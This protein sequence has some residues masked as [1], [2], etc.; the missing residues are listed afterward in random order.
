MNIFNKEKSPI[1]NNWQTNRLYNQQEVQK[2]SSSNPQA[3]PGT[4][5]THP[6]VIVRTSQLQKNIEVT[7]KATDQRSPIN[8]AAIRTIVSEQHP[9]REKLREVLNRANLSIR[10]EDKEK[11]PKILADLKTAIEQ[12]RQEIKKGG[13]LRQI[14]HL[15]SKTFGF[16]ITVKAEQAYENF[17]NSLSAKDQEYTQ[18]IYF[19]KIGTNEDNGS[20]GLKL[21]SGKSRAMYHE[22][23]VPAN[24]Y[25]IKGSP[26]EQIFRNM[27][28]GAAGQVDGKNYGIVC[29]GSSSGEYVM[30]AAQAFTK[31][32]EAFIRKGSFNKN[33]E[34]TALE[35]LTKEV[36]V[37]ASKSV[38][39]DDNTY[40][41]AATAVFATFSDIP[42]RRD[43]Y[44]V[45]GGAIGDTIAVSVNRAQGTAKQLN[46]ITKQ[47]PMDHAD[48]GGALQV[49]EMQ[50]SD[51]EKIST[52]SAEVNHDDVVI[53][54][55]DGLADNIY[56]GNLEGLSPEEGAAEVKRQLE[57]I[58]PLIIFSSKFDQSLEELKSEGQ[59]WLDKDP[60][61]LPTAE[62]LKEFTKDEVI[63]TSVDNEKIAQR[64]NNYIKFITDPQHQV[65]TQARDLQQQ[66]IEIHNKINSSSEE[67][68]AN[69]WKAQLKELEEKLEMVKQQIRDPK[70]VAKT[71]DSLLVI[72]S[73]TGE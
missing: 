46:T 71:D 23:T 29:D 9:N 17:F 24:E 60:P 54:A 8:T 33:L 6:Q 50:K 35:E 30:K 32:M 25:K 48:S 31:S 58:L 72:L 38:K 34:P 59:P 70:N 41:K 43:I 27:D 49:G 65:V 56:A 4:S 26:T 11:H 20:Q 21:S 57:V 69:A 73:P 16:S 15:F 64:L 53:L 36:F 40:A 10:T 1:H 14:Q 61:T 68:N 44:L 62:D 18:D 7:P 42:D 67:E 45:N 5:L 12:H 22:S 63:D 2:S 39:V 55:S 47:N 37:N 51:L 52:F 3:I 13:I 66:I 28:R 19:K